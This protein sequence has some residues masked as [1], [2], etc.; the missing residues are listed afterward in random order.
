[1]LDDDLCRELNECVDSGPAVTKKLLANH[2]MKNKFALDP[3]FA[4]SPICIT[5]PEFDFSVD[6]SLIS[7]VEADPFNGRKNDDVIAHL[8]KLSEFGQVC[9]SIIIFSAIKRVSFNF[10]YK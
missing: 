7:T 6:L 10:G 3:T 5:D 8:T 9:N 1:M 4:T 2:S